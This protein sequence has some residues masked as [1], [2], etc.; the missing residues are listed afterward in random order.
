MDI[1]VAMPTHGLL[2]RD[3]TNFYLQR[4]EADEMRVVE[5]AQRA[6]ELG[7]HS[8]WFS[9]HVVMGGDL[10]V[11]YPAN[12]SG[13]KAYPLRPNMLDAAVVMGALAATTSRIKFAPSVHIA[14]YRHPLSSAHQF[15]T[16]DVLSNGRLIMGVGCGWE[17]DE[18]RALDADFEHRG[19]LTEECIEIYKLAWSEPWVEFHG[20]FFDI[21]NVSVDPKPV[22]KPH[23]PIVFGA[24]TAAG[25]RRAARTSDALY[26]VHL[27]P[28]IEIGVWDGLRD[29]VSE[30]AERIERDVGDFRMMTFASALPT[31]ASDELARRDPRPTLT[32][33]PEQILADLERFA[34]HGYSHVTLHFH[35]RSGTMTELFELLDRFAQEILPSAQAIE[36]RAFA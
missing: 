28:Y 31:D 30:E 17:P 36:A 9:D 10:D 22:Q 35:V 29:V 13:K 6:E 26:T 4:V 21:S 3:E 18:F 1:G 14:P 16:V 33:A 25:A 11:D 5:Y 27:E 19:A 7:Y 34:E 12:L 8:V 2:T 20:R 15:A 32:G 24:T 23:P